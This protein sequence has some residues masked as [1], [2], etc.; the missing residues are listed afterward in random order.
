MVG[1]TRLE[2]SSINT[3]RLVILNCSS[4]LLLQLQVT[5]EYYF[6][7]G[8]CIPIR[9]HT[10]VI[11]TQHSEKISLEDLRSQV[12]EHVI[13]PVIPEKLIDSRTVY[14]INPCGDFIIGGPM[15]SPLIRRR[16]LAFVMNAISIVVG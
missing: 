11:S 15:V 5:C 14:H 6:D 13:K 7:N 3:T 2:I 10:V 16:V 12:M 4:C 8:A 9:V 1:Q